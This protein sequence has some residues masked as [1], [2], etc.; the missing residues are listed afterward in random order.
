MTASRA[1]GIVA[2]PALASLGAV[3]ICGLA[4]QDIYHQETD[5]ALEWAAVRVCLLVVLASQAVIVYLSLR[6]RTGELNG[7]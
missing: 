7:Q 6:V 5:V 3:V 2:I 1:L 4:L